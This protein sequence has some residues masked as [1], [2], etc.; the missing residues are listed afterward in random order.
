[1][2]HLN[3]KQQEVHVGF[4]ELQRRLND[5]KQQT[6]IELNVANGLWA[7][8]GHKFLPEFLNLATCQYQAELSQVDFKMQAD[9]AAN[10]INSW[11]SKKTRD[12]IQNILTPGA[13]DENTRLVLV[14][15]IYFKGS[16]VKPFKKGHTKREPFHLSFTS[17][18]DAPLMYHVDEVRYVENDSFQAVELPY[19]G[20]A[21]STVVLLPRQVDGLEK[22]EGLLTPEF[23]A[24]CLRQMKKRE[25]EIHLPRFKLE[26]SFE[27]S[28]KLAGMGM[29]DVFAP[30]ANLS[31]LDGTM[32]LFVR[33]VY[34][35]AWGEVN[36]EGTEAA[37]A[38]GM[39]V[40][41][42][43]ITPAP[44]KRPAF[45]ADHPFVFLIR[46]RQSGAI[47]FLGR[48][49]DPRGSEAS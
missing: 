41:A 2:L 39:D 3:L 33:S 5:A 35:K 1:V 34:H 18:T 47:L 20:D 17:Q 24:K 30:S 46:E 15:A 12:R 22:L 8:Q 9:A 16:W 11:V 36:E 31:G 40:V 48:L 21:L 29:P 43:G 49:L 45:R 26:S 7:Q 32:N 19:K 44:P 6:G 25:V 13:L 27:L 38:T 37:T 14:N 4:G 23:V 10:E 28:K 42:T